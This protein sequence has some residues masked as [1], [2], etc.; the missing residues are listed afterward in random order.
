[1]VEGSPFSV[2]GVRLLVVVR[3]LPAARFGVVDVAVVLAGALSAA[4]LSLIGVLLPALFGAE[5]LLLVTAGVFM[6]DSAPAAPW[7]TAG[8]LATIS[9][10]SGIL[11]LASLVRFLVVAGFLLLVDEVGWVLSPLA[12]CIP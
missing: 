7:V 9:A 11:A 8:L 2:A 3:G 1:L 5:L 6:P 12:G 10:I 4:T